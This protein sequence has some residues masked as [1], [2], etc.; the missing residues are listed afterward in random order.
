V[1]IDLSLPW[2]VIHGDCLD[3][4][5][6]LPDG[7]VDAVVTDPPYG[8]GL[9]DW[10][11]D[12]PNEQSL[13]EQKRVGNGNVVWFGTARP[14]KQLS[15][16]LLRPRRTYV[17]WN[18]FTVARSDGA[19]WQWQPFYVWGR[20]EGMGADVIAMTANTESDSKK[21]WHPCQKPLPLMQRIVRGVADKG[22]I[23]LDP[24]CGSGSTG[25]AAMQEGM[26]FIGIEREASYVDIARRRIADAA[27]QGNLFAE[28]AS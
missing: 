11:S 20:L 6:G 1:T 13:S 8:V 14:D 18:T 26:R 4:M 24:F 27:A 16:L 12:I 28:T 23:I 2:Q 25:V 19:F 10:D 3:V 22:S 17:W 5:R 9:A 7:C 15:V 21:R